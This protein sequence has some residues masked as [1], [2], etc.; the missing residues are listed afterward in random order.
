MNNFFKNAASL[1]FASQIIMTTA[2]GG[3]LDELVNLLGGWEN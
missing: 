3:M 2:L 1:M